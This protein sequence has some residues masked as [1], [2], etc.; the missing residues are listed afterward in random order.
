MILAADGDVD[1][2]RPIGDYIP[3]GR[4]PGRH[5]PEFA[6]RADERGKIRGLSE[7]G[8]AS[9]PLPSRSPIS[10]AMR[11]FPGL[12]AQRIPSRQWLP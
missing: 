12:K 11:Q 9:Q 3:R 4:M 5:E 7:V 2:D 8:L 6:G 10:R 1:P